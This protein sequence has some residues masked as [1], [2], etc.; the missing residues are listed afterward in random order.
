MCAT[1]PKLATG[2]GRTI[3]FAGGCVGVAY[4]TEDERSIVDFLFGDLG[5]SLNELPKIELGVTIAAAAREFT[6]SLGGERV[7]LGRTLGSLAN[8]VLEEAARQLSEPC[9]SGLLLHA[10]AVSREG[11]TIVLPGATGAGKTTLCAWLVAKGYGYLTDEL[12]FLPTGGRPMECF[13]RPLNVKQNGTSCIESALGRPLG[14]Q[15]LE[16]GRGGFLIPHRLLRAQHDPECGPPAL[17]LFPRYEK[18][19]ELSVNATSKA[20]SGRRLM[21]SLMNARN[22]DRHG[23]PEITRIAR[24]VTGLTLTYGDFDQLDGRL[25]PL[26]HEALGVAP[27][28]DS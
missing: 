10:A 1:R 21:E 12:V 5:E 23:F 13:T 22:L 11:R 27:G 28:V 25:D 7:W 19:V 3:A 14:D 17:F 16:T 2:D 9:D 18:G 24:T 4:E 8:R 20:D 6:L 26:L 15:P